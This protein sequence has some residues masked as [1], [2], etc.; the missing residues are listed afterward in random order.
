MLSCFLKCKKN[1]ESQNPSDVKAKNGRIILLSKCAVC[2]TTKS[3]FLIF[4]LGLV[5]FHCLVIY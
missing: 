2:G 5:K 1:T 4:D 3:K